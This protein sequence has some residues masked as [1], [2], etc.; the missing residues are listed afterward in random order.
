MNKRE[1]Q[2]DDVLLSNLIE[3][4]WPGNATSVTMESE[5]GCMSLERSSQL[6]SGYQITHRRLGVFQ[7][8]AAGLACWH[9]SSGVP[10]Y[11]LC[12]FDTE[13]KAQTYIDFL[14][15]AACEEALDRNDFTIEGFD[16]TFHDR[17]ISDYPVPS[18]W[19]M[20]S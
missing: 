1:A 20:P 17:L 5:K 2:R 9:P 7:G 10:E 12:R 8:T 3:P 13:A 14:C 19:E 18:A 16:R 15:S 11:G 4:P 6:P